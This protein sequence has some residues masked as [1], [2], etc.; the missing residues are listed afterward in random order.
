MAFTSLML[1]AAALHVDEG[2]FE[3]DSGHLRVGHPRIG[4]GLRVLRRDLQLLVA[5]G[6]R[7]R[8]DGR[9]ALGELRLGELEDGLGVGVAEVVRQ[10]AVGVDVDEAGHEV[11]S[12]HV[13]NSVA[14]LRLDV[15]PADGLYPAALEYNDGVLDIH[16]GRDDMGVP[17]DRLLHNFT[18]S[19]L[20]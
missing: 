6:E 4:V 2:A 14:C 11:L 15:L 18:S 17:D 13:H 20:V 12:L 1:R 10:R 16:V 8:E 5:H 19:V 7:R 3:V 9:H